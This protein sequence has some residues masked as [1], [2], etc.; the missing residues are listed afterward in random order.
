MVSPT[1]ARLMPAD[2]PGLP[3]TIPQIVACAV[4]CAAVGAEALH[5]HVRD[6]DGV[7]SID[8]GLY[9]EALAELE[10]VLPGF[11]VQI[12]TEAAGRFAPE[13]QY[14]VLAELLPKWVSV[15]LREVA[16]D[17]AVAK[18]LYRLARGAGI[19][20]QHIVYDNTDAQLLA[21]L[22]KDSTLGPDESVILVLGNYAEKR[23]GKTEELDQLLDALP[24]VGNWMACAFGPTE[25]ACLAYAH[26]K[27]GDLRV[28]FENSTTNATGKPWDS[29]AASVS[30][31]CEALGR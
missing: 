30:A 16:R 21:A 18:R 9:R 5:L 17:P 8:A 14:A 2:H 26:E 20:L 29:V 24:P 19:K 7:H 3:V 6:K 11:P 25:H 4:D 27:G 28:G 31:L 15:S 22:Q 23:A 1:G 10:A 12:T 13:D